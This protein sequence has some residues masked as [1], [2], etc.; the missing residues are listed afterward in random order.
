[1]NQPTVS[2]YAK[3]KYDELEYFEMEVR[4]TFMTKNYDTADIEKIPIFKNWLGRKGLQF[5]EI[6][7]SLKH[8]KCKGTGRLFQTLNMLKS[9][10]VTS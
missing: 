9:E 4:N 7:T 8:G 1:M 2:R 6:L 5:I 10:W 3:N